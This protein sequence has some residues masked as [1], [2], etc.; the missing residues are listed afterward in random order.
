MRKYANAPVHEVLCEFA[1]KPSQPWDW[2]IPGLLYEKIKDQFPTKRQQNVMTVQLFPASPNQQPQAES[3]AKLQFVSADESCIVQVGPDVLTINQLRPYPGWQVFLPTVL[4]QLDHYRGIGRPAGISSAAVR[5]L[6]SVEIG[7]AHVD[8]AR[9]FRVV[10]RLPDKLP[11]TFVSMLQQYEVENTD[12]PGTLRYVLGTQPHEQPEISAF[13]LDLAVHSGEIP[14]E[15]VETWLNQ[16]HGAVEQA[17][18]LTFTDA[19]HSEIFGEIK[20]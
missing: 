3:I 7:Q 17:F 14:F 11:R 16:A 19:A 20:Q 10:P 6:N 15:S 2:T 12:P 1:F 9:Y 5:Y 4:E 13:L 8:L 18:Y